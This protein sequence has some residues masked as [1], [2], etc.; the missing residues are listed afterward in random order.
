MTPMTQMRCPHSS[1]LPV[2]KLP[3]DGPNVTRA[4][5]E[6]QKKAIDEGRDAAVAAHHADTP[7]MRLFDFIE[8][9]G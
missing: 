8:R 1:R 5:A 7:R 3:G 2:D 4:K 9:S 6:A